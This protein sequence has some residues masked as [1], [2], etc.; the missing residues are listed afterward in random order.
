TDDPFDEALKLPID[1]SPED[2][3]LR[4]A[5]EDETRRVSPAIDASIKAERQA[6]RKKQIVRLLLLS[7]R[8]SG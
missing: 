1:E 5:R 2:R 7:Q 4:I 6:R 8:E 3:K